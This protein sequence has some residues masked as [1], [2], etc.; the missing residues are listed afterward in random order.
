MDIKIGD[1][2]EFTSIY[3]DKDLGEVIRIIDVLESA[4]DGEEIGL[5][6]S[7]QRLK[8]GN[9]ERAYEVK[10]NKIHKVFRPIGEYK[11]GK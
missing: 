8:N 2:V 11:N 5:A 4:C 1:I 6:Y 3:I 10:S 9:A 7:V